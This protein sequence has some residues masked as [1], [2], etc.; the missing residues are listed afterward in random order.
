MIF[1]YPPPRCDRLRAE[2]ADWHR[3]DETQAVE[4]LLDAAHLDL[5]SLNRIAER[6]RTLVGE[7][8]RQHFY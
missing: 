3:R 5:A 8:R 1:G 2:I 7:V 4:T 6:A